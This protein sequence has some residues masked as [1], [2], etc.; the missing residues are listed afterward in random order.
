MASE[1]RLSQDEWAG[2]MAFLS[3]A[4]PRIEISSATVQVYFDALKDIPARYLLAASK[5]HIAHSPYFPAIAELRE[6]VGANPNPYPTE[7][8]AIDQATQLLAHSEDVA[9]QWGRTAS[10]RPVGDR[11]EVHPLVEQAY[12]LVGISWKYHRDFVNCYRDLIAKERRNKIRAV[13]RLDTTEQRRLQ[14]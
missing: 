1:Q 5:D 2:V 11:P 4:Y 12:E 10:W 7:A 8:E 9:D 14:A 13:A 3:A 6:A